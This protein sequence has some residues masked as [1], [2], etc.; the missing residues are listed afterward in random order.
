MHHSSW[1]QLLLSAR[2]RSWRSHALIQP[3]DRSPA[4]PVSHH[5]GWALE[6][7]RVS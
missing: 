4:M 1:S 7:D 3:L 2:A 6:I 5:S